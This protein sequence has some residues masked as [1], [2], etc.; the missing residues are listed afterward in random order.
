VSP[1]RRT[2]AILRFTAIEPTIWIL[3]ACRRIPVW[4]TRGATDQ[5]RLDKAETWKR[6]SARTV[7]ARIRALLRVD[8]RALLMDCPAPV[9][10]IAGSKDGVVP[11]RNVEQIISVGQSVSVRLID[12]SHFALYTNPTA[13]AAAISAFMHR[14]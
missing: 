2:Y 6:V 13:S 14:G 8:A 12:G 3:R 11:R 10:C 1:P 5:L 9:L 4:L 7:A